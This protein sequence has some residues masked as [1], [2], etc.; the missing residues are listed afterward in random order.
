MGQLGESDADAVF[1]PVISEY[2]HKPPDWLTN[3][4]IQDRSR[5]PSGKVLGWGATR[6]GNVLFRRSIL[7]KVGHFDGRFART[8]SEDTFFFYQAALRGARLVWCDEAIVLE[9]V[10]PERMSRRWVLR[11]HFLGGRNYVFLQVAIHGS[12]AYLCWWLH[13]LVMILVA[14]PATVVLLLVGHPRYM[15]FASKMFGGLGKLVAP[16]YHG[17]DYAAPD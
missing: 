16:F 13:G 8:G 15:Q 5:Y 4:A 2:S 6:T 11:R 7:E 1:G 17:G 14:L 10:P 9:D 12:C 3:C